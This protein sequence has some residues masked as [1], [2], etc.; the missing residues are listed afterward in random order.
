[1]FISRI[2][3]CG[4]SRG[5]VEARFSPYINSVEDVLSEMNLEY[6]RRSSMPGR[7]TDEIDSLKVRFG[8]ERLAS[9]KG[10]RPCNFLKDRESRRNIHFRTLGYSLDRVT[11]VFSINRD[12]LNRWLYNS[13]PMAFKNDYIDLPIYIL[14]MDDVTRYVRRNIGGMS[15]DFDTVL[16]EF[17]DLEPVSH[18]H[19]FVIIG[20]SLEPSPQ[21]VVWHE[22]SMEKRSDQ[23][24]V[25]INRSIEFP[26]EFRQAGLGILNYF[27]EVV[28][29]K[30][31]N[32]HA[33]IK[34]EQD[35]LTVR[36]I[37][38]AENGSREIIEK[39]LAEYE[40]VVTGQKPPEF[41]FDDRAKIIELK[42]ELRFALARIETQKELLEYQ[43]EDIRDLKQLFGKALSSPVKPEIN[44]T[45]SPCI[46]VS[47]SQSVS[48]SVSYSLEGVLEDIQYLMTGADAEMST[49]LNDLN[50]ALEGV[51]QS[52]SPEAMKTSGGLIKLKKF[53][54]DAAASGSKAHKFINSVSDG[55]EILRGLAKKYNSI[56][57]WCGAP[58]VPKI[59]VD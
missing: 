44:L 15:A 43:R 27:G 51:P 5:E 11:C 47:S 58:Q 46:T 9:K 29:E 24:K 22:L 6:L 3:V 19:P 1:M 4:F 54:D 23:N 52:N 14:P 45:V 37:I 39:A 2:L 31:P 36:M 8:W 56:A 26:P 41:L 55:V 20:A 40:L 7:D 16:Q 33:K 28:R 32:E 10:W 12:A 18:L 25:V 48:Q 53:I 57:E 59:F 38:E 13:S 21:G 42:T 17:K 34:I 30:Y 35:G 50:E 49:R